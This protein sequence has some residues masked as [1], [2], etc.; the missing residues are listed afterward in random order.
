MDCSPP[1]SSVHG[2]SQART[3]EWVAS[4]SSRR[5]SWPRD[6]THLSFTGRWILYCWVTR[7]PK[8]HRIE[9]DL[10]ILRKDAHCLHFL[11]PDSTWIF[12][13]WFINESSSTEIVTARVT[14]CSHSFIYWLLIR[15]QILLETLDIPW[16]TEQLIIALAWW[17]LQFMVGNGI[18]I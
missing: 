5:S 16:G 13:S 8:E 18:N 15:H 2:M 12:T 6:R 14:S 10:I 3:L 7:E 9:V 4:F 17:V 1:G 11:W